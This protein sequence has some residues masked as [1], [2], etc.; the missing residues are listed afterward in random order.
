MINL[1]DKSLEIKTGFRKSFQDE[2]SKV[3]NRICYGYS[4]LSNGTLMVNET[5]AEVVWFIF[6]RYN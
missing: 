5:K 3:A 6:E 2:N 4:K 1:R